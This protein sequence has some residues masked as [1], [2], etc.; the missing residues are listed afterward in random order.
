MIGPMIGPSSQCFCLLTQSLFF[1]YF[2]KFDYDTAQLKLM[3][4]LISSMNNKKNEQIVR[5]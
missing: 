5:V 4:K 3:N 2:L 1:M